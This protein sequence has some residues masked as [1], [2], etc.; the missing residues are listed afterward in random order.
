MAFGAAHDFSI[1]IEATSASIMPLDR[2]HE[3]SAF[4][5]AI[6]LTPP[7]AALPPLRSPSAAAPHRAHD[8]HKPVSS[9]VLH[10]ARRLMSISKHNR[11]TTRSQQP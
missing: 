2:F 5:F 3:K 11:P 8:D 7:S 9:H 6:E 4:T 10:D 1:A